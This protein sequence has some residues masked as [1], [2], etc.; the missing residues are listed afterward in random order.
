[1]E[2][3]ETCGQP[4]GWQSGPRAGGAGF[5]VSAPVFAVGLL[6]TQFSSVG[7]EK[8]F[9]QLAAEISP[10][11]VEAKV[12]RE[13]LSV[14]E[15]RF[16]GRYMCWNFTTLQHVDAF[17]VVPREEAEVARLVELLPSSDSDE[18]VH[19]VVGR[20]VPPGT[21][22]APCAESGLPT[23]IADQL[24][25]FTLDEFAEALPDPGGKADAKAGATARRREKPAA[26]GSGSREQFEA[27]VRQVFNRLTR[28]ADNRGIS[29][30]HRAINYVAVQY[31]Q[32]Y[33]AV[34]QANAEGKMLVDIVARHTHSPARRLVSL[35]IILRHQR[36]DIAERYQCV[37]DVTDTFPFLATRLQQT[38]G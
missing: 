35:E 4:Q 26:G 28:R 5:G 3:C 37:V 17:T 8:Q 2:T 11:L 29:D 18:E 13:V 14:P 32:L 38:F 25:A 24:L 36:T 16:L 33:H 12:L 7:A 30:E 34:A 6:T 31:P 9:A 1:V 10:G 21:I 27:V 22:D 23:V 15:N 20:S 19:V